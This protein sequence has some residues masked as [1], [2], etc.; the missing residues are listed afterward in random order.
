MNLSDVAE[1]FGTDTDT[2]RAYF[3]A[4]PEINFGSDADDIDDTTVAAIRDGWATGESVE[5]APNEG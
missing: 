5:D 4:D 2:V 3:D 1:E